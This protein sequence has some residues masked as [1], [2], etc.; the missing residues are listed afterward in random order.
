M[1]KVT[2]IGIFA[3][4]FTIVSCKK[5][6]TT[7]GIQPYMT[8]TPQSTWQYETRDSIAN[9]SSTY[10]LT[11][12]LRDTTVTSAGASRTY[13]VF[14]NSSNNSS[15]YYAIQGSDYFN[16]REMTLAGTSGGTKLEL[17]YLR[18][19][20]NVN[21][22]WG[23]DFSVTALGIP[24][25]LRINYR[26]AEK[27]IT[28]VVNGITYNNVIKVTSTITSSSTLIPS[29]GLQ[30]DIQ[31]YYAPGVGSIESI[32]KININIPLASIVQNIST[33]SFLK[34]SDIK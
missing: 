31:N 30:S 22:T 33:R 29:G 12:T 10:T 2:F 27:G 26:L 32:S 17:P 23:L 28:R 16:Y 3:L 8:I 6:N 11:S 20:A 7:G 9:T 15:E 21:D 18:D 4:A 25:P 14:T 34:S 5:N 13:H 24:V 1:K 19:N